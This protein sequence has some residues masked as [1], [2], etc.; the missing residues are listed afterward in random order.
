MSQSGPRDRRL[1]LSHTPR[2][3]HLLS[4]AGPAASV[5]QGYIAAAT[6]E[7]VGPDGEPFSL[8]TGQGTPSV[9]LD[10]VV[11]NTGPTS[12]VALWDEP[13]PPA[14]VHSYSL[15]YRP[16]DQPQAAFNYAKATTPEVNIS[17]LL[18]VRVAALICKRASKPHA[19]LLV[20]DPGRPTRVDPC[21]A[22]ALLRSGDRVHLPGPGVHRA[23]CRCRRAGE[24]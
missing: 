21:I 15:R 11:F 17:G 8:R 4:P 24:E 9:P 14:G 7:G 23:T 12:V 20:R 18:K 22:V 3:R 6:A 5:C 10:L 13:S 19:R 2:R 16:F 1:T